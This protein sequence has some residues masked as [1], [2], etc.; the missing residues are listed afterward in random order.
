MEGRSHLQ[1]WGEL[2]NCDGVFDVA[3]NQ[4]PATLT[5]RRG[6]GFRY[7]AQLTLST[8]GERQPT[9]RRTGEQQVLNPGHRAGL[10][11]GSR[12]RPGED[13]LAD[14]AANALD[15]PSLAVQNAGTDRPGRAGT[16]GRSG[17]DGTSPSVVVHLRAGSMPHGEIFKVYRNQG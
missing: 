16:S 2:G 6:A 14:P 11:R 1:E 13:V 4:P 7:G 15:Q 10:D 5:P 8:A 3:R 17:Q 12:A 9:Q